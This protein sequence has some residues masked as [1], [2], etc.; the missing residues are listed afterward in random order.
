MHFVRN[1]NPLKNRICVLITLSMLFTHLLISCLLSALC[2]L[3]S[4]DKPCAKLP[5]LLPPETSLLEEEPHHK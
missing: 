5:Q 2:I 3:G 1:Q 4:R